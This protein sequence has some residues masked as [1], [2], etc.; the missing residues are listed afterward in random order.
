MCFFFL[1][2]TYAET[3]LL[4][5]HGDKRLLLRKSDTLRAISIR[6]LRMFRVDMPRI[7]HQNRAYR[8]Y[9][10]NARQRNER[11]VLIIALSFRLHR[12]REVSYG[13]RQLQGVRQGYGGIRH[14]LFR[15]YQR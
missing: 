2:P 5:I 3:Q 4:D 1:F 10:M 6:F 8:I 7:S 15:K 12:R 14:Q 13:S 11:I 9:I